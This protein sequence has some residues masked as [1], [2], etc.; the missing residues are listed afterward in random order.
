M[1]KINMIIMTK[2]KIIK[3]KRLYSKNCR[4]S[5]NLPAVKIQL[6]YFF[7]YRLIIIEYLFLLVKWVLI[8]KTLNDLDSLSLIVVIY[9]KSDSL[10]N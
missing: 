9:A 4:S 3:I 8:C 2:M 7:I 5:L 1:I 6:Y 10:S